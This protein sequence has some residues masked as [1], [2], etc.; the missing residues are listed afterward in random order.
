M[1]GLRNHG[2]LERSSWITT[3]WWTSSHQNIAWQRLVPM[4]GS[5][6]SRD[7]L[8]DGT[9]H[10]FSKDPVYGS[11]DTIAWC[12]RCRRDNHLD[13]REIREIQVHLMAWWCRDDGVMWSA[14]I[15]V[16]GLQS[17]HTLDYKTRC[18]FRVVIESLTAQLNTHPTP[19]PTPLYHVYDQLF[20]IPHSPRRYHFGFQGFEACAPPYWKLGLSSCSMGW[21]IIICCC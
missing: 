19:T 9:Y 10:M 7:G 11:Y 16:A 3:A 4:E 1:S 21:S 13:H 17:D 18:G 15:N 5:P 12:N 2:G 20:P 6:V 8:T 14:R